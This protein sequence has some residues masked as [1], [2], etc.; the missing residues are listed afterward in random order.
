MTV[1]LT[2]PGVLDTIRRVRIG[3]R[4]VKAERLLA[5]ILSDKFGSAQYP[6]P[7]DVSIDT[8]LSRI[9][10]TRVE[11]V[12]GVALWFAPPIGLEMQAQS[13][14]VVPAFVIFFP[15]EKK[16]IAIFT[17]ISLPR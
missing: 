3:Y 8:I 4:K 5:I 15:W 11:T 1:Y 16:S 17:I 2:V 9:Q 14:R 7:I 6:T 10:F 12:V 13:P